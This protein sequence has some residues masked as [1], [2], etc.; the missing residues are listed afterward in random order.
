MT[1]TNHVP[2]LNVPLLDQNVTRG[3]AFTYVV[4]ALS[5]TDPDGDTLRYSAALANGSALPA[6]LAFDAATR[7]FS[8]NSAS[9]AAGMSSIIVTAT[10]PGGLYA[11]DQFELTVA[12]AVPGRVFYGT[13]GNDYIGT[14]ST[15]DTVYAGAGND[16]IVG[17]IGDNVLYGEDGNDS[18]YGQ[19]GND[20]MVGG[21]GNDVYTV[22]NRN[23]VVVEGFLQGNDSVTASCDYTLPANVESLYLTAGTRAT[24]NA[25]NNA[26]SVNFSSNVSYTLDGGYGADTLQGGLGNDSYVVDD[27]GDVVLEYSTVMT[28]SGWTVNTSIDTVYSSA[29]TFTLPAGIENLVLTGGGNIAGTGTPFANTIVGNSGVNTLNGGGGNDTLDGGAGNDW[30][31]GGAGN[32]TYLFGRGSGADTIWAYELNS[33]KVDVL[34]MASGIATSD[35]QLRQQGS[36]LLVNLAGSGDSVRVMNHFGPSGY[37]IDQIRFADGT[38]WNVRRDPGAF[39][40]VRGASRVGGDVVDRAD[41]ARR[42]A[43]SGCVVFRPERCRTCRP[44]VARQAHPAQRRFVP[45]VVGRRGAGIDLASAAVARY[46]LDRVAGSG[47]DRCDGDVLGAGWRLGIHPDEPSIHCLARHRGT[48]CRLIDPENWRPLM[49]VLVIDDHPLILSALRSVVTGLADDVTVV[50]VSTAAAARDAMAGESRFELV[51]LDLHLGEED[52]FAFLAELRSAHPAV[53]VVVVSASDRRADVVRAMD[54]GALGFVPKCVGNDS[55]LQALR[56]VLSG[57]IYL[58]ASLMRSP[59]DSETSLRQLAPAWR[60][61]TT[62]S[63]GDPTEAALASLGL[64]TRQTQ[65]LALLLRGQSNKLIARALNLSVETIKDHVAAVLRSLNV[66]SRTQAVLAVSRISNPR[67]LSTWQEMSRGADR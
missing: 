47:A 61:T 17:G 46:R 67:F 57:G 19:A 14:G 33:N 4:P 45:V 10:D 1:T 56:V 51:L 63:D 37:Q 15:N 16:V 39:E 28:N 41:A 59:G 2:T 44:L 13:P 43:G 32:D 66:S 18:I 64:T 23:D 26:I 6:W 58:P 21:N 34:Q 8:G 24:G 7:T 12:D 25:L 20:T 22:D 27:P 60:D 35:V 29:S 42:R 31:D 9:A 53:P 52:G 40:R 30:L 5:F 38:T 36:D 50:A 54:L 3:A 55:L 48:G 11:G 65:V 62:A 49:N